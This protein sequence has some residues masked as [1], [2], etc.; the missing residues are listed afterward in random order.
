MRARRWEGKG[1]LE[2]GSRSMPGAAGPGG[3]GAAS[4]KCEAGWKGS[5]SGGEREGGV[6]DRKEGT[7]ERIG[8]QRAVIP[9][10]KRRGAALPDGRG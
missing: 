7:V 9:R 5:E 6:E 1:R 3:G 8:E 2:A 10:A 4:P